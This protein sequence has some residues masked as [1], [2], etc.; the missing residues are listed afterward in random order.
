[1]TVSIMK[2]INKNI[3]QSMFD[4]SYLDKIYIFNTSMH[5]SCIYKILYDC[6]ICMI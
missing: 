2:I 6:G 1:M 5:F 3:F 4:I